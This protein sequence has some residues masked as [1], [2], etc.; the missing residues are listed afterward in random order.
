LSTVR[1]GSQI[2]LTSIVRLG[3]QIRLAI[4]VRLWKSDQTGEYS[5]ASIVRIESAVRLGSQ[6][7]LV[8]KVRLASQIR[9]ASTVR[10]ESEV[11]LEEKSQIKKSQIGRKKVRLGVNQT[12]EKAEW[13]EL[14][15]EVCRIS[16]WVGKSPMKFRLET[17]DYVCLECVCVRVCY[18]CKCLVCMNKRSRSI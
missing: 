18:V 12:A 14:R 15:L 10:I 13:K 1:L 6:I 3:S 11:R 9:L 8:S 5:L 16:D 7:S 17:P 2:R 4:I